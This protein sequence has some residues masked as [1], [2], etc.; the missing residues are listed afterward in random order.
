MGYIDENYV[1][2]LL[3]R[4]KDFPTGL[5]TPLCSFAIPHVDAEN[6]KKSTVAFV[7]L[8]NPVG[9]PSMEDPSIVLDVSLLFFIVLTSNEKHMSMLASI[10]NVV[11]EEDTVTKLLKAENA[12]EILNILERRE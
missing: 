9:W 6:V 5:S 10:I 3:E 7:K 12:E 8:R 2:S 1:E 4:E 11:Q